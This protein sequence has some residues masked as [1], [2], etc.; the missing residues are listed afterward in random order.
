MKYQNHYSALLKI[1]D[2]V[3][4]SLSMTSCNA[5][6][7]YIISKLQKLQPSLASPMQFK[8]EIATLDW[9]LS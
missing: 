9:T 2:I 5:Y 8:H 3:L 7:L 4:Y 6:M 1:A